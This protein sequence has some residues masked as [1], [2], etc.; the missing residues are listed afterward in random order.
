MEFV[1]TIIREETENIVFQILS[2]EPMSPEEAAEAVRVSRTITPQK[3]WPK[4]NSVQQVICPTGFFG[5][6]GGR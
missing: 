1:R 4:K 5:P 6:G 3:D 2:V